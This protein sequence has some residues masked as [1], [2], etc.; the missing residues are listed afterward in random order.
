M[1][2]GLRALSPPAWLPGMPQPAPGPFG[3]WSLSF[4]SLSPRETARSGPRGRSRSPGSSPGT[5]RRPCTLSLLPQ[6]PQDG[7][8]RWARPFRPSRQ[9][10]AAVFYNERVWLRLLQ[11]ASRPQGAC[12]PWAGPPPQRAS[13]GARCWAYLAF[14]LASSK[15][16]TFLHLT[17]HQKEKKSETPQEGV[18]RADARSPGRIPRCGAQAGP[19][20]KHSDF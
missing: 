17:L 9:V 7:M 18:K 3:P 6:A 2:P 20:H 11:E 4:P 16:H 8:R 13:R 1:G 12:P 15:Q 19:S 14:T 10:G 5:E